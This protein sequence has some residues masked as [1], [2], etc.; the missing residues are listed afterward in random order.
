MSLK[1]TQLPIALMPVSLSLKS[2][3][4]WEGFLRDTQ[5]WLGGQGQEVQASLLG[6]TYEWGQFLEEESLWVGH[7]PQELLPVISSYITLNS[8]G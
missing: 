5:L 8:F 2:Q 6:A 7:S 4:L 3:F 1:G